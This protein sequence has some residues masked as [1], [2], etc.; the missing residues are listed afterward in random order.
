[1]VLKR[2]QMVVLRYSMVPRPTKKKPE[3][4]EQLA[5]GVSKKFMGHIDST[6]HTPCLAHYCSDK[7]QRS[8]SKTLEEKERAEHSRIVV[9][10]QVFGRKH[11]PHRTQF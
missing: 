5:C 7:Q 2:F 1:M 6:P 8:I 9:S 4:I 10:P 11:E 3:R